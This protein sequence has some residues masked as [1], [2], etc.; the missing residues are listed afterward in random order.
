[1]MTS[2]G[3]SSEKRRKYFT[4]ILDA[5]DDS[6]SFTRSVLSQFSVTEYPHILGNLLSL[7]ERLTTFPTDPSELNAWWIS[8]LGKKP[9]FPKNQKPD[10][11][12]VEE[13][14]EK[15]ETDDEDDWRKYFDEEPKGK[16]A[17]KQTGI[18]GRAYKLTFHQSLHSLQ[19]HRAVFT[20]LWLGFLPCLSSSRL[21]DSRMLTIRVLNIMHGGVLPHLTRPILVM[22]W[23]SACVDLGKNRLQIGLFVL[24][25]F[26]RR[27]RRPLGSQWSFCFDQGLQPVRP[28]NVAWTP[29]EALGAGITLSFTPNYMLSLTGTSFI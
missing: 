27:D 3:V 17:K 8:E 5:F 16:E 12:E 22:D 20:K 14:T 13:D 4:H 1:M 9:P 7:I 21:A 6:P 26:I 2:G 28:F 10:E 11:G 19:A 29:I 15:P 18:K 24:F 23:I 25:T